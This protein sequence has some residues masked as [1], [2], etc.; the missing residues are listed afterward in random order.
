MAIAAAAILTVGVKATGIVPDELS[1][2]SDRALLIF[3]SDPN[4]YSVIVAV[5]AGIVG[6]L[7]LVSAKSGAMIGV[8]I[9]VTTIT[10]AANVGVAAAYGSDQ[11]VVPPRSWGSMWLPSSAAD[12]RSCG[13]KAS[14]AVID[15]KTHPQLDQLGA[16]SAVLHE[17][18]AESILLARF[19]MIKPI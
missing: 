6:M 8:L 10:A 4:W 2:A 14:P 17:Q 9:S 12:W 7:A 18:V 16:W 15:G 19:G 3:I 13:S 1:Q 5:L 11:A